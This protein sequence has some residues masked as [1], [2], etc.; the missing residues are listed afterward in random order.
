MKNENSKEAYNKGWIDFLHLTKK[1]REFRNIQNSGYSMVEM[2]KVIR[3][4]GEISG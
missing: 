3:K 1:N 2:K 4:N